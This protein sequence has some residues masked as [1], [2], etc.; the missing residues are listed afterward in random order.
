MRG[1]GEERVRR[2]GTPRSPGW[3]G[4]YPCHPPRWDEVGGRGFLG[5]QAAG[6]SVPARAVASAVEY[7]STG[8]EAEAGGSA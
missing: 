4:R 2:P 8:L 5:L 1:G 6:R 7:V 3:G